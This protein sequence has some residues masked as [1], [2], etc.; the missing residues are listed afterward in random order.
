MAHDTKGEESRSATTPKA[1]KTEN[2]AMN[3]VS[4]NEVSLP[5][6]AAVAAG[7]PAIPLSLPPAQ[8]SGEQAMRLPGKLR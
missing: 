3:E 6:H 8:S 5:E 2:K 7:P 1:A 4:L